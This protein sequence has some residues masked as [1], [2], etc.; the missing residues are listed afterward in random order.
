MRSFA[1][2]LPGARLLVNALAV[3][4]TSFIG[5]ATIG[6]FAIGICSI[7][8]YLPYKELGYVHAARGLDVI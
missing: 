1:Q 5:S 3:V 8:I 6:Y 4:G 2:S 7:G